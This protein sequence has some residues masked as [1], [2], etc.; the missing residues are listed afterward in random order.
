MSCYLGGIRPQSITEFAGQS[1]AGKT[2]LCLQLCITCQLPRDLGG[3]EGGQIDYFYELFFSI[4][5]AM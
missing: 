4:F 2:Q 1:A 5:V 3:L